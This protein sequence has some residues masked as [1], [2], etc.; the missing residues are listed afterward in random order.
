M[1]YIF[2]VTQIKRVPLSNLTDSSAYG[3]SEYALNFVFIL[4]FA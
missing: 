4:E 1:E 3:A 2:W